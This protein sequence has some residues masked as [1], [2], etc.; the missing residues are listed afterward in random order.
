LV[1]CQA[2]SG[3]KRNCAQGGAGSTAPLPRVEHFAAGGGVADGIPAPTP[4]ADRTPLPD[5]TPL[6]VTPVLAGGP[7]TIPAPD[8]RSAAM[9]PPTNRMT[10]RSPNRSRGRWLADVDG[11]IV[12]PRDR[13]VIAAPFA[14]AGDSSRELEALRLWSDIRSAKLRGSFAVPSSSRPRNNSRVSAGKG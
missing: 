14:D 3:A 13:V 11:P 5:R 12:W 7:T 6:A 9:A 1:R 8:K 10:R 2:R 4:L